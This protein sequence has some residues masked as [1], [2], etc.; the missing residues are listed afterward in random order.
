M[1]IRA[2]MRALLKRGQ[3][4]FWSSMRAQLLLLVGATLLPFAIFAIYV[5]TEQEMAFQ[6]GQTGDALEWQQMAK[7]LAAAI[8]SLVPG[9]LV[10]GLLSRRM[11]VSLARLGEGARRVAAGD[12]DYRLTEGSTREASVVAAEFNQMADRLQERQRQLAESEARFRSLTALSSDWYWEQD[13]HYRFTGLSRELHD[14]AGIGVEAHIGKTRWDL[15]TLDVTEEQWRKH[16]ALLDARKPF[17]NFIFERP[18]VDGRRYI[19][20]VSGEPVFDAEGRF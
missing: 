18:K 14:K 17:H 20:K 1:P 16:R 6:R 10:A 11:T 19:V 2:D 7:T 15:P 3:S 4:S 8:V 5:F 12:L 13:E 9:L